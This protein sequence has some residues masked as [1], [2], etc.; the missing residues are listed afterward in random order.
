MNPARPRSLAKK[1][2]E[3]RK[4]SVLLAYAYLSDSAKGRLRAMSHH[5]V[6]PESLPQFAVQGFRLLNTNALPALA[7]LAKLASD[8]NHPR[9][10]ILATKALLAITNTTPKFGIGQ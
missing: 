1:E 8:T 10:Q 5:N 7:D 4:K 6:R 3:A 9:T 2:S